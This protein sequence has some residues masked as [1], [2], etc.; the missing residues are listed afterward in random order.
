MVDTGISWGGRRSY[1]ILTCLVWVL[2]HFP[3]GFFLFFALV[4]LGGYMLG[5]LVL[6]DFGF[7]LFPLSLFV[8]FLSHIFLFDSSLVFLFFYPMLFILDVL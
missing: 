1:S 8:L 2:V 4:D 3:K 5:L 6:F 7:L